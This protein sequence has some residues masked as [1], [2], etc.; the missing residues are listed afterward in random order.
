MRLRICLIAVMATVSVAVPVVRGQGQPRARAPRMA[1]LRTVATIQGIRPG[2]VLVATKKGDKWAITVP[3]R[4]EA[5]EYHAEADSSWLQRGMS[6]RF[7]VLLDTRRL[8]GQEDVRSVSV[9]T[10]RQ[11]IEP[12]VFPEQGMPGKDHLFTTPQE[13][14]TKKRTRRAVA[15]V[16]CLVIGRLLGIKKGNMMVAAGRALVRAPLAENAAVTIDVNDYRLA[17]LGDKV[18]VNARYLPQRPGQAEGEQLVITAAKP[19]GTKNEIARRRNEK[20][21]SKT[22]DRDRGAEQSTRGS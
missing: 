22:G 6:I 18:E 4:P 21:T 10:L 14:A 9:V 11:G 20:H 5:I 8:R 3:R 12:G 1:T 16:P 13:P 19:L 15:A 2:I 17:R 7:N